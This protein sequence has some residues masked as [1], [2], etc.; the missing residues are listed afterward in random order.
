M[1]QDGRRHTYSIVR[2][3]MHEISMLAMVN[4]KRSP[5]QFLFHKF[6]QRF[7]PSFEDSFDTKLY[8]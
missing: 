4:R 3:Q 1:K 5:N 7:L 8:V 2:R 6:R